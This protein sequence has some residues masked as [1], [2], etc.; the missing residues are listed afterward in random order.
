MK[1][2]YLFLI[3]NLFYSTLPF[4]IRNVQFL[5]RNKNEVDVSEKKLD[6]FSPVHNK[7]KIKACDFQLK[8]CR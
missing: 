6:S 5:E 2:L 8:Y 1:F 7:C 4:A 3:F